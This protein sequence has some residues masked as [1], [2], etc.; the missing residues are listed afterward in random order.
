[1]PSWLL[2][3]TPNSTVINDRYAVEGAQP[4]EAFAEIFAKVAEGVA[5]A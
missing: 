3:R 2:P 4:A 1:L 5:P